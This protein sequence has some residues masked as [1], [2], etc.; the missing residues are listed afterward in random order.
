MK[1][2]VLASCGFSLSILAKFIK[3]T[4]VLTAILFFNKLI[5]KT[6]GQVIDQQTRIKKSQMMLPLAE[7]TNRG[8]KLS[9]LK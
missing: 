7:M 9:I 4:F 8:N 6:M 2:F 5:P 1:K 3:L